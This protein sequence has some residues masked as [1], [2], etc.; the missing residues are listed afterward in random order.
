[1][2][3]GKPR[4]WVLFGFFKPGKSQHHQISESD[5]V[6]SETVDT[7]YQHIESR[8]RASCSV[9]FNYAISV[10]WRDGSQLELLPL[11]DAEPV[12]Y[13]ELI[14]IIISVSQRLCVVGRA[15]AARFCTEDIDTDRNGF[16]LMIN[17]TPYVKPVRETGQKSGS[18]FLTRIGRSC[19]LVDDRV[20]LTHLRPDKS[21]PL[22]LDVTFFY[23]SIV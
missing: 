22:Y 21:W 11:L 16:Q 19:S 4:S 5:R 17:S 6:L 9:L 23:W 14:I 3:W 15:E 20:A 13:L 12:L 10:R 7:L 2:D 18:Y 1:L 8:L